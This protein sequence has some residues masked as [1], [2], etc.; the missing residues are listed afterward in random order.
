MALFAGRK[1]NLFDAI[2]ARMLRPTA[3]W[4]TERGGRGLR[5]K[6]LWQILGL[7]YPMRII[8]GLDLVNQKKSM[9]LHG[10]KKLNI[11]LSR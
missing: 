10:K 2:A 5:G 11:A 1:T 7:S 4:F 6:T 3:R 9:A 8:F